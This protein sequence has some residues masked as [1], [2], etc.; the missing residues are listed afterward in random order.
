VSL[1]SDKMES[2]MC[3]DGVGGGR[4]G[5]MEVTL[6]ALGTHERAGKG[7]ASEKRMVNKEHICLLS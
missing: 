7:S 4:L 3:L 5:E 2:R 6:T 1:L